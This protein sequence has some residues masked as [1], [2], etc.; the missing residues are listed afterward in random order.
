[1][2][3]KPLKFVRKRTQADLRPIALQLASD[4]RLMFRFKTAFDLELREMEAVMNDLRRAIRAIDP[5]ITIQESTRVI[6]IVSTLTGK[7]N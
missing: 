6:A 2:I 5:G 4:N 7:L 1:M 3:G